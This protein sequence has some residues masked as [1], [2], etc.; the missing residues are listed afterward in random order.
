ME[1]TVSFGQEQVA[2]F[3]RAGYLIVE[4]INTLATTSI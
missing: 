3:R 1:V 4:C 2:F